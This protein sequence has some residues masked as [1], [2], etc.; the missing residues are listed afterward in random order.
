MWWPL[1]KSTDVAEVS[2]FTSFGQRSIFVS[3][4][5]NLYFADYHDRPD[6]L[7]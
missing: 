1:R 5:K 3:M 2:S 7:I 6:S 4:V